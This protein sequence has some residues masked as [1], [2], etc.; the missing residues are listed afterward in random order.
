MVIK[1]RTVSDNSGSLCQTSTDC[2]FHHYSLL[3][4]LLL[5]LFDFTQLLVYGMLLT[6]PVNQYIYMHTSPCYDL[7][8]LIISGYD[9][10]MEH[11]LIINILYDPGYTDHLCL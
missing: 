2:S 10:D 8:V 1:G 9:T 3:L 7:L 11:N 6:S 5:I 4:L